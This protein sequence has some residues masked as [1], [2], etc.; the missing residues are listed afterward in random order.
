MH[1]Q[2]IVAKEIMERNRRVEM[3]IASL[4]DL[5]K[6]HSELFVRCK[7]RVEFLSIQKLG[8]HEAEIQKIINI[9][10]AILRD[11]KKGIDNGEQ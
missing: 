3:E 2:Y 1:F 6:E 9:F 4:F 5:M 10:L 11:I 8:E 7:V